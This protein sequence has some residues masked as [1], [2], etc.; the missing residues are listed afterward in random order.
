MRSKCQHEYECA[1]AQKFNL[2]MRF[3]HF[4]LSNG[5]I[6]ESHFGP[7]RFSRLDMFTLPR[8]TVCLKETRSV[9]DQSVKMTRD[10][11]ARYT[12]GPGLLVRVCEV[13]CKARTV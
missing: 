3:Q 13:F 10:A 5:W 9:F 12:A 4:A 6:K 1:F 7:L 11:F 8:N 2:Q